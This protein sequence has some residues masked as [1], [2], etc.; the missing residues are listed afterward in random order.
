MFACLSVCLY[1]N[2]NRWTDQD[3]IW[4]G[5]GP[6]GGEG[7]WGYGVRKGGAEVQEPQPFVLAFKTKVLGELMILQK[8]KEILLQVFRFFQSI[9]RRYKK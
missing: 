4:H 8:E 3:E 9:Y 1:G 5:G 6:Q 2:P 7:S